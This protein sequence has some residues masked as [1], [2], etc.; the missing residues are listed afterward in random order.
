MPDNKEKKPIV[1]LKKLLAVQK[2]VGAIPK[3]KQNPF[4]KSNYF[5]INALLEIVKPALE[6]EGLLLLQPLQSENGVNFV[7]TYIIDTISGEEVVS[8]VALPDQPDPQKIGSAITYYRRYTLQS[9]LALE[10]ADDD[11]NAASSH[12]GGKTH[13]KQEAQEQ[14]ANGPEPTTA[15]ATNSKAWM[16]SAKDEEHICKTCGAIATRSYGVSK[17]NKEFNMLKCSD[18][19]DHLE[20]LDIVPAEMGGS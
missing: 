15:P 7:S 11:G 3:T 1:L 20:W 2:A 6:K 14:E 19:D 12:A 9:I 4:Y 17:K 8:M 16:K 13:S 10:A 5:D 18:K